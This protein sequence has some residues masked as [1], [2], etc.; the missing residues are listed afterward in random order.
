MTRQSTDPSRRRAVAYALVLLLATAVWS[1]TQISL[2]EPS[3]RELVFGF[4]G[5]V[6]SLAQDLKQEV[7]TDPAAADRIKT[8]GMS[9]FGISEADFATLT[10]VATDRVGQ[11]ANHAA[12]AAAYVERERNAG[13]A[14]TAAKLREY[15]EQRRLLLEQGLVQL[16][17][18]LSPG[19][20]NSVWSFMQDRLRPN[21]V[22][23]Q[24]PK[25]ER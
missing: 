1:Q 2:A 22:R 12:G 21:L 16:R 20:W 13:R 24:L 23:S 3:D 25:E 18:K 4:L 15:Q 11:L 10:E 5:L 8:A 7:Q 19:G 6:H 17:G 14:P 9:L